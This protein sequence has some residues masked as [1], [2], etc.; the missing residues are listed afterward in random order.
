MKRSCVQQG[1]TSSSLQGADAKMFMK[2]EHWIKSYLKIGCLVLGNNW[3]HLNK[4]QYGLWVCDHASITK[5]GGVL[6][7]FPTIGSALLEHFKRV[8]MFSGGE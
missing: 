3:R 2:F 4:I 7:F 1:A 5:F 8:N 6:N